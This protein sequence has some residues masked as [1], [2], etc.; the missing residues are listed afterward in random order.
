MENLKPIFVVLVLVSL[1]VFALLAIPAAP[2]AACEPGGDSDTT[3]DAPLL[4]HPAQTLDTAP[5]A[6]ATPTPLGDSHSSA[7]DITDTWQSIG[8]GES[9]WFKTDYSDGYR[10]IELWVDSPVQDAL[11]LSIF[12]P[13]QADT[14]WKDKPVGR[15]TYNKAQP[16]HML[17]WVSTYAQ[18]GVWYLFLQNHTSSPVPYRLTSNISAVDAKKCHGYWEPLGGQSVYW[19]DCGHY[20]EVP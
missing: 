10:A 16:Q 7:R 13:D 18:A 14:W 19:I 1:T 15:G 9:I 2:A 6:T 3:C 11:D 12:S 5:V 4:P 17:T 8:P 20:T